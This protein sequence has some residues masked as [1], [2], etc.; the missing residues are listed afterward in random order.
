M[1][2][3]L[4]RYS[5]RVKHSISFKG[6]TRI[7]EQS[8]RKES[9]IHTILNKYRNTGVVTHMRRSTP[10]FGAWPT[11]DDYMTAMNKIA[12]AN[13]AF[14]SLPAHIKKRF[15]NNPA[16]LIDFLNDKNNLEEGIKLGLLK[17][18]DKS[19]KPSDIVVPEIIDEAP[20]ES[21][22]PKSDTKSK[23]K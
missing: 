10:I 19:M 9:D 20:S 11:G 13:Q 17:K 2:K 1:T 18:T 16:E 12:R 3:V 4:H 22:P 6:T 5:P 7:T 21:E 14:D 23:K 8:Q 15:N